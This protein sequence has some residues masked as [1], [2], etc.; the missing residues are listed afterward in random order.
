MSISIS[1][2]VFHLL[3]DLLLTILSSCIRSCAQEYCQV[4]FVATIQLY[5]VNKPIHNTVHSLLEDQERIFPELQLS[6]HMYQSIPVLQGHIDDPIE[7][8][9][10]A[11]L[12]SYN[13][14]M[15]FSPSVTDEYLLANY[16]S[17]HIAGKITIIGSIQTFTINTSHQ[18]YPM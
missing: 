9:S 5:H 17:D 13:Y 8:L 1:P 6:R 12:A 18:G 4:T 16:H 7:G 3:Q 2:D 14:N 11:I 10:L 15:L